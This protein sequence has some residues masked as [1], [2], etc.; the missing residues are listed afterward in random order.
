MNPYVYNTIMENPENVGEF[1]ILSGA[2]AI[3]YLVIDILVNAW[4]QEKEAKQNA[5]LQESSE[6]SGTKS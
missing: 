5:A 1:L 2:L 4:K 3:V 6:H